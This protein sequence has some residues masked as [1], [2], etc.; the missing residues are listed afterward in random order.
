MKLRIKGDSLRLRLTRGELDRFAREGTVED[1]IR[2][3]AGRALVYRLTRDARAQSP[4][5]SFADDTIEVRLPE[6]Q[7]REWCETDLVTVNG[8]Q[9]ADGIELR[10][11]V[12][13]D[14]ACLKPRADE[15]ES[16]NF[17]HPAAATGQHEC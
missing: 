3:G 5:A 2:F 8:T 14:F 7:A 17:P 6:S 10:I 16:D 9:R 11:V 15:D 13:K 4:A 1:R 12:E